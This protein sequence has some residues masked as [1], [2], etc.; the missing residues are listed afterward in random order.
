MALTQQDLTQAYEYILSKGLSIQNLNDGGTDLSK[1][2]LAPVIEYTGTTAKL[3]RLAVSLLKGT[4]G[5]SAYEDWLTL[6]ENTGKPLSE[7]FAQMKG[8]KGDAFTFKD[9]TSEQL[10]DLKMTFDRMTPSQISAFWHAIPADVLALFQQPAVAAA[11]RADEKLV[12]ISQDVNQ[13]ITDTEEANARADMAA[14]EADQARI[15]LSESVQQK[16]TEVDNKMLT[17]QDGKTSQFEIGT[18]ENGSIPSASLTDNGTDVSGNPKKKLN[19]IFQKGDKGDRGKD[20]QILG[21]YDT[22]ADLRSAI[23]N[24]E[25]GEAYG[26]GAVA[27]Y[28]IYIWDGNSEDWVNNGA[29]QGPA[30]S[31]GKSAR[32]N[33][34]T[35][36]WQ[37]YDDVTKEWTD[38]EYIAQYAQATPQADG[39]MSKEDKSKLD[40]IK[41]G[42]I[43]VSREN[44]EK[45]LT[46]D[47][48]S[49]THEQVITLGD[50]PT[51]IWDG[52]SIS[53][54][55]KGAGTGEDPYLV[56]SCADWLHLVRNGGS[57]S[58]IANPETFSHIKVTK[59][60]DFDNHLYDFSD[61]QISDPMK[62]ILIYAE[63]EGGGCC[64][65]NVYFK[66]SFSVCYLSQYTKIHDLGVLSGRFILDVSLIEDGWYSS[67]FG[68]CFSAYS[69]TNA[70]YNCFCNA[71]FE[72]N[73]IIPESLDICMVVLIGS[74]LLSSTGDMIDA[75]Y[76]GNNTFINR[77]DVSSKPLMIMYAPYA[78]I[79]PIES[80]NVRLHIYDTSVTTSSPTNRETPEPGFF[81]IMLDAAY[82]QP[83]Y[84]NSDVVPS[85]ENLFGDTALVSAFVPK[86]TAELKS[87]DFLF[88]LNNG[89][90]LFVADTDNIN[91]GYPVFPKV[92]VEQV[93]YDGYLNALEMDKKLQE[94]ENNL[95]F[96]MPEAILNLTDKSTSEQISIAVGGEE[97][98]Y[99][100]LK[101]VNSGKAIKAL[102]HSSFTLSHAIQ[103]NNGGALCLG[104]NRMNNGIE[105]VY[106]CIIYTDSAFMVLGY[107]CGS[108]LYDYSIIDNLNSQSTRM[109]L[110]A[111]QGYILNNRLTKAIISTEIETLTS[112]SSLSPTK[113]NQKFAYTTTTAQAIKFTSVP[114]EGFE[115]M[116]SI[117]NNT[118]SQITQAIP[119]AAAWQCEEA[120]LVIPAGKIGFI[121]IQY[122]FD[123]YCVR[124]GL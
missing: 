32:V 80:T 10:D 49:H 59:N 62:I 123:K 61:I 45:V 74:S 38:T 15:S 92:Q 119:N 42:D 110:S 41:G 86:T 39:L 78:Q 111:R 48:T 58:G 12:Q 37:E 18:V 87:A 115:C 97:G 104:F 101:L 40:E 117:K 50:M 63:I 53:T 113:Y 16:L 75:A 96:I 9:F 68:G 25:P 109:P 27:P 60:M 54:S 82:E 29:I 81:V 64:F 14:G 98:F 65:K 95:Y 93:V 66:N 44:I 85:L 94:F 103:D 90:N 88:L 19:L 124:V 6:P 102:D 4:T 31:S 28:P 112:L 105:S 23:T 100:L 51:D 20:F 35:G 118:S 79:Q 122:V 5:K 76:Y 33:S 83:I 77:C 116:I 13:A 46:G 73:G 114:D 121:S 52:M 47:I 99:K 108:L 120:S 107:G 106:I 71:S 69:T 55:L 22:I 43:E 21:Y 3:V 26:V 72:T 36:Y 89:T 84:Y 17:V 70:V 56:E 1:M 2:Y 7:F 8:E 11:A 24:P 30:G 34:S 91:D 57:Y 67:I